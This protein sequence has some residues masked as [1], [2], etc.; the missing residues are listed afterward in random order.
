MS[1]ER[2]RSGGSNRADRSEEKQ[3]DPDPKVFVGGIP[4]SLSPEDIK[5]LFEVHGPVVDM[6]VSAGGPVGVF[7]GPNIDARRVGAPSAQHSPTGTQQLEDCD[8][9]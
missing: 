3:Y 9:S 8:G 2:D 7:Y 6:S 1:R 4:F 5:E